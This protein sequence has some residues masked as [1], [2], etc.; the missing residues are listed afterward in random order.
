[1]VMLSVTVLLKINSEWQFSR[2]L[3]DSAMPSQAADAPTSNLAEQKIAREEAA[4]DTSASDTSARKRAAVSIAPVKSKAGKAELPSPATAPDSEQPP[5]AFGSTTETDAVPRTAA[6]V[7]SLSR[8][9]VHGTDK[10]EHAAPAQTAPTTD[11][12]HE[13]VSPIAEGMTP[14]EQEVLQPKPWLEKIRK[15]LQAKKIDDARKELKD[16]KKRY[17][18]YKLPDD[19]KS[20]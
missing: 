17:P 10:E 15:L 12:L 6:G 2:K 13:A 14:A 1:L 3:E 18:D 5:Q 4:F 19:L 16:F 9:V 20:L 7:S 11:I 8:S